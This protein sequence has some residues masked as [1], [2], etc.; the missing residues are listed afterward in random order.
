MPVRPLRRLALA[1][2]MLALASAPPLLRAAPL[3]PEPPR[4]P[5]SAIDS[6]SSLLSTLWTWFGSF[7]L[8]TRCTLDPNGSQQCSPTGS[9]QAAPFPSRT[10][11]SKASGSSRIS[12]ETRCTIDP[13]GSQV[14]TPGDPSRHSALR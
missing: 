3:P 14:C 11:S 5:S 7:S 1:V 12:T 13:N 10:A 6:A 4:H 2:V 9:G 8:E